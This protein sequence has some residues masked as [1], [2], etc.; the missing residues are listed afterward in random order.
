MFESLGLVTSL[1]LFICAF[2]FIIFLYIIR[3]IYIKNTIY[4]EWV[5]SIIIRIEDL[6]RKIKE[7]DDKN[8]FEKDDEVGVV[9]NEIADL[10]KNFDTN[11]NNKE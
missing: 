10:I 4:E 5:N 6:Q 3:N 7:L 2:I 1:L 8:I 9:F 11:K